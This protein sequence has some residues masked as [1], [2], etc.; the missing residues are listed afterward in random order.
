MP[1]AFDYR[2]MATECLKHAAASKDAERKQALL[3]IAKLY[4]ESADSL[5]ARARDSHAGHMEDDALEIIVRRRPELKGKSFE[6]VRDIIKRQF[7]GKKEDRH[8]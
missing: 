2:K 5:E 8:C 4:T 7:S 6:E 3:D 1:S